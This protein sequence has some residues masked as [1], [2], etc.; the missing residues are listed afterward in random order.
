[1]KSALL[2][3][4]ALGCGALSF[5][6]L[7][8]SNLSPDPAHGPFQPLGAPAVMAV[9]VGLTPEV[10]AA[11]GFDVAQVRELLASADS[12]ASRDAILALTLALEQR[13]EALAQD[14]MHA[15]RSAVRNAIFEHVPPNTRP[16]LQ[17][18]VLGLQSG[19]P[20]DLAAV[21]GPEH[22]SSDARR[23]QRLLVA[24]ARAARLSRT[25]DPA[26]SS[27]L[28]RLR[29]LPASMAV[30]ERLASS[31]EAISAVFLEN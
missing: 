22:S 17:R 26:V 1:M 21:V 30:R 27:E 24:E 12:I 3:V 15:A 25:L 6:H 11:A 16:T 7:P 13:E 8:A 4:A 14:A 31:L 29:A 2:L 18:L 23:V 19:L 5:P 28:R 10:L 9:S 20:L